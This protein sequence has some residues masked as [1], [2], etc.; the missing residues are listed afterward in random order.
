[1]GARVSCRAACGACCIAPSITTAYSGHPLG[2]PAGQVCSH[3]T[4]DFRCR[5]W[6]CAE[7]PGFC[8]GL[9]P[10][11]EMCGDDRQHA[12][13]WLATLEEATRPRAG[14]EECSR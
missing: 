5:L 4:T 3:L 9:Q 1:M 13:A 11:V 2:K 8:A 12:L 6:G 7:R 14:G 10:S